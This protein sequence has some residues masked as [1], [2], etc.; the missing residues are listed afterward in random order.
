M[1]GDVA[2]G[3]FEGSADPGD[4]VLRESAGRV[5]DM[6][7]LLL[8]TEI[9][10]AKTYWHVRA[11]G[12]NV[13]RIYP[14]V[15]ASKVVGMLW[16][17][18]AQEQTWFGNEPYKS[19]GIQLMPLTPVSEQRDSPAWIQEMLPLFNASCA[20]SAACEDDGWSVLVLASQA[21]AGDWRGAWRGAA[22]LDDSVF[23]A[24]GGNGHSRTNT[25]WYIAT[26]PELWLNKND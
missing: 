21:T 18:L 10:T 22:R 24:A 16:S 14:E 8:A 7:R 11:A 6:G 17:M 1:Y 20:L 9:R 5:R 19:Y 15:Y 2:A 3:M 25:L 13:T 26:R 23:D 12:P 4:A